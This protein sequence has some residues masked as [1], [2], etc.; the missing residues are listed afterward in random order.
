MTKILKGS[1]CQP[2][3]IQEAQPAERLQQFRTREFWSKPP[4][5]RS[6]IAAEWLKKRMEHF[7]VTPEQVA[8]YT[9]MALPRLQTI[10]DGSVVMGLGEFCDIYHAI[11]EADESQIPADNLYHH[12]MYG[13][14]KKITWFED[15]WNGNGSKGLPERLV[16]RFLHH[17]HYV[18]DAHLKNWQLSVT[19]NG[20]LKM[21]RGDSIILL[22]WDDIHPIKEAHDIHMP[23]TKENFAGVMELY[24][25]NRRK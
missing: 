19:N 4:L 17:I 3:E 12:R 22:S 2:E 8:M 21:T 13:M 5:E 23:F 1:T 16:R 20:E 7:H 10:L 24:S 14:L 18:P 11:P 6:R 25:L 15:G 9:R